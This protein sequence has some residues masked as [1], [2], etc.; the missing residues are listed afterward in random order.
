MKGNH[1]GFVREIALADMA[2]T[3]KLGARIAAHLK[4][5]DTVA[6]D[7]DLGAGKT[8]LARAILESLGV[9]EAVP[10]PTFTLVQHYD[11]TRLAVDHFDLYRIEEESELD[12]LGLDETLATGVALIEW[13]DRAAARIP[14]DALHVTLESADNGLRHARIS[15]PAVWAAAFG[16]QM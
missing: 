9:T 7:G 16:E 3:K 5:G 11:T 6:L 10:S 2:A 12:Q 4:L 14:P 8:A 13:P 15:G 1:E